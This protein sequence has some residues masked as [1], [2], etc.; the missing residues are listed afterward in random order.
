MSESILKALM[1]L[2][3]I[4]ADVDE[5]GVSVK[6]RK[7]VEAYLRQHLTTELVQEY[8]SLFDEYFAFH[9]R[10]IKRSD[11]LK[12]RKRKASNSVK[13]LMICQQINESLQQ[14][15]KVIV[16]VRLLE[17]VFAGGKMTENELD[18]VKTVSDTFNIEQAEYN[19]LYGF[20]FEGEIERI[21]KENL[22]FINKNN[23]GE[24]HFDNLIGIKNTKHLTSE[25]LDGT[26]VV[27]KI[28]SINT[29]IFRYFG[30]DELTVNGQSIMPPRAYIFDNGA[31]IKSSKISPIYYS[32]VAA[33]FLQAQT[34]TRIVLNADKIRF[35]FK[36]SENG[37]Y[38]MTISEESG[39]L[40]GIMGGSGV[41]KST[42]LNVLNGKYAIEEGQISI[43]QFDLYKDKE[44]LEGVIGFVPQDDLLIEELTVYQNLYYNAKLCFDNFT[45]AQ[46]NEV[47]ENIL[48][49]LDLAATRDLTVGSPL[50][51]F[52]SGGQ[53]KRLNIALELMREPSILFVDEPTSGLSSMDSEMVMLLLKEQTL[54]GKLVIVNIHQPSSEI[55]KL[56]DKLWLLDKG[57]R[58]IYN[59]NPVDAIT[60]FKSKANFVNPDESECPKCGNVNPEQVLQI[61]ETKVVNE[62]GQLTRERKFP[63]AEWY[64]LYK[65][66]IEKAITTKKCDSELPTNYFKVPNLFKQFKIFFTRNVLSKLTNKQYILINFLEAPLLALILGFFTKYISG[67]NLDPTDYI[68]SNNENIPAYLFMSIVVALFMGLTVSAE[69]IIRDRKI[70]EREKFLNLSKFSYLNSKIIFLFTVSAIQ[71]LT[72]VLI[73]N[74][75][76]EIKGM[77]FSYWFILFTTACLANMIGLN[78]SAGLDSVV[79]IYILIPL[80]LVP[81]LLLSGVIVSFDKLHRSIS[82]KEYVPLVGDMMTSR[83]AYEALSVEQFKN[84]EY[85][86]HFFDLEMQKSHASYYFQFLIPE[87]SSKT[88]K[89]E[90]NID[91]KE[92][93]E[94]VIKDLNILR[95]EV[96]SFSEKTKIIFKETDKLTIDKFDKVVAKNLKKYLQTV[97]NHYNKVYN[98]ANQAKDKK[99]VKLIEILGGKEKLVAL[100]ST[101]HN[102][103]LADMVTNKNEL[104]KIEEHRGK[105][106]QRKDPVYQIPESNWGR[107]HF[108]APVKILAG[109]EIDTFWFNNLFIWLTSFIFYLTLLH[110]TLR[111]AINFFGEIKFKKKTKK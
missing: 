98:K 71:M 65:E 79:T 26:L 50:K 36:N 35:R 81:Q 34:Q 42:L 58:I 13:V 4:I 99:Y 95:T 21:K 17:Y 72:Y 103:K 85:Q 59:G 102:Q 44:K 89:C 3:A 53:R 18:F 19:D 74:A 55:Y 11:S 56:F 1:R 63:P 49:D 6:S 33:Q 37:I 84:N 75:I 106:I 9:H 82:S 107:A 28:Q 92:E 46:I 32:N 25:Q 91:N 12:G 61:I 109:N 45:E 90:K 67:S 16:L 5:K 83:W 101:Y 24:E 100:Q 97:K 31:I 73:G 40:I 108:Y 48:L 105:L 70:L 110:D 47:V 87:L 29:F 39:R 66:N 93:Q 54:K 22:L 7:I 78:I 51:K 41:G 38:P 76:L 20:I 88:G 27:L 8:L 77:M 96:S 104:K 80:I 94:T 64:L 23:S 30:S 111:K 86:K 60:Y 57:G 52:I 15:E 14:K 2:F 68:F 10:N 62:Q 69:E 43:N